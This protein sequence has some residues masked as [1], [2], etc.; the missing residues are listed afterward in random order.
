LGLDTSVLYVFSIPMIRQPPAND[1][2]LPLEC[3]SCGATGELAAVDGA[4]S[5][6]DGFVMVDGSP[7]CR[8]GGLAGLR[9]PA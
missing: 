2:G 6:S 5:P 1:D 9:L 8:C 4:L 7:Q 3:G